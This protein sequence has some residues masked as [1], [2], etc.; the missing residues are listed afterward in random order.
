MCDRGEARQATSVRS[1]R[2]RPTDSG[3]LVRP[4]KEGSKTCSYRQAPR[5]PCLR[6]V[7][8]GSARRGSTTAAAFVPGTTTVCSQCL[9]LLCCKAFTQTRRKFAELGCQLFTQRSEFSGEGYRW[10]RSSTAKRSLRPRTRSSAGWLGQKAADTVKLACVVCA[11]KIIIEAADHES[12]AILLV[13][14]FQRA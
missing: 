4:G 6:S 3:I 10:R 9:S 14:Q 11:G 2:S 13:S 1:L 5:R 8:S 7:M 12:S